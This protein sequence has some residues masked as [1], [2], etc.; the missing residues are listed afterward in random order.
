MNNEQNESQILRW[1]SQWLVTQLLA[2]TRRMHTV[3]GK[4]YFAKEDPYES[5]GSIITF[6]WAFNLLV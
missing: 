5:K 3:N 2:A 6:V 4:M 1:L